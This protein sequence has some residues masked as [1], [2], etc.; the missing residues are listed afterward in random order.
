MT[1]YESGMRYADMVIEKLAQILAE[2]NVVSGKEYTKDF[3]FGVQ[4]KLG[5][6]TYDSVMKTLEKKD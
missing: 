6:I 2:G 4:D 5:N 1:A 3:Y